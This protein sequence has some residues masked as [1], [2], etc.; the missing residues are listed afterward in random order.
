VQS[1]LSPEESALAREVAKELSAPEL[2]AWFDEL[3]KL[4]VPDAVAKVRKLVSGYG[5]NG[6]S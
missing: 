4:S 6:A 5:K 1:A 3:G 2:R